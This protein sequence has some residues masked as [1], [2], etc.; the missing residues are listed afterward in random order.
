MYQYL[1]VFRRDKKYSTIRKIGQY[2]CFLEVGL[3]PTGVKLIF[4]ENNNV[5]YESGYPA[6]P[7]SIEGSLVTIDNWKLDNTERVDLQ[8][9]TKEIVFDKSST[10]VLPS[11]IFI[12][13]DKI[14][15]KIKFSKGNVQLWDMS[16]E[17]LNTGTYL[18]TGQ[19]F[20]SRGMWNRDFSELSVR[21]LL[22]GEL[23]WRTNVED[24]PQLYPTPLSDQEDYKLNMPIEKINKFLVYEN[25]LFVSTGWSRTFGFDIAT[26]K[27]LWHLDSGIGGE[28]DIYKDQIVKLS[29]TRG[30]EAIRQVSI[31]T[32]EITKEYGFQESFKKVSKL[33][34]LNLRNRASIFEDKLYVVNPDGTIV[35]FNL[36]SEKIEQYIHFTPILKSGGLR[37]DPVLQGDYMYILDSKNKVHVFS[38]K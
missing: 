2:C 26:G 33:D 28:V 3:E 35:I 20:V 25:V 29:L 7:G 10:H 13:F 11:R 19:Y 23:I 15:N 37:A 6:L 4:L 34:R 30:A 24:F 18:T 17:D 38:R 22:T 36:E 1:S 12:W 27:K 32:G 31:K 8:N 21:N 14:N 9:G 5:I 16:V